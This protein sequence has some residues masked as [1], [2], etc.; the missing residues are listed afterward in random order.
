MSHPIGAGAAPGGAHPVGGDDDHRRRGWLWWL[1]GLLALLV[2][3]LLVVLL[4][5]H[6]TNDDKTSAAKPAPSTSVAA[7]ASTPAATS[8]APSATPS[9]SARVVATS[10]CRKPTLQVMPA[11]VHAGQTVTVIGRH[12]SGCHATTGNA[13]PAVSLPVQVGVKGSTALA[14]ALAKARTSS[15]GYFK[16]RFA[17]PVGMTG[18]ARS[19]TLGAATRD[20]STTLAYAGATTVAYSNSNASAGGGM[21]TGVPA[22]TGGQAAPT[23]AADRDG[24]LG[25]LAGGL[26]LAAGGTTVLTRRRHAVR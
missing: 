6:F 4:V 26:L 3:A 15:S 8:A 1:C 16:V 5:R 21:P 25:L 13:T 20:A 17:I 9:S 23:S 18:Q 19:L 12:F 24:L 10:A 2:I 7:P 11:A 14:T 22:G